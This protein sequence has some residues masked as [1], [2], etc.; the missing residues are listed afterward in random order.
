MEQNVKNQ[1]IYIMIGLCFFLSCTSKKKKQSR[2]ISKDMLFGEWTL[3]GGEK[4]INYP[5]IE[6]FKDGSAVLYSQADTLYR[7]TF[8]IR[9]DSLFLADIN[10]KKYA[11]K[12]EDLNAK[13]LALDGIADVKEKQMFER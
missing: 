2:I 5:T 6:F 3:V 4:Q 1:Y 13:T 10:G 7:F 9:N 8:S 11:N 12:I